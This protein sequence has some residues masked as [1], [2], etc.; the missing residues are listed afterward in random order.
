MSKKG[1]IY[2]T[3]ISIIKDMF[4][5]FDFGFIQD[6]K[7]QLKEIKEA[8]KLRVEVSNYI[9][10][11]KILGDYGAK[12]E[13]RKAGSKVILKL[14]ITPYQI[15][16]NDY[17]YKKGNNQKVEFF[18]LKEKPFEVI[19]D[20]SKYGSL[21]S[22][23]ANDNPGDY[24]ENKNIIAILL[25]KGMDYHIKLESL[26]DVPELKQIRTHLIIRPDYRYK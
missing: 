14:T 23:I 18:A 16:K 3:D 2:E 5:K 17:L 24:S 26:N 1:N 11:F 19:M 15:Q 21:S 4:Y 25:E 10:V 8:K 7:S 9:T 6:K 20:L 22:Y 13:V 12:D